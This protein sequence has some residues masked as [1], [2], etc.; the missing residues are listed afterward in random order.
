MEIASRQKKSQ[1]GS[2][3]GGSASGSGSG[4]GFFHGGYCHMAELQECD[5]HHNS[6]QQMLDMSSTMTFGELLLGDLQLAPFIDSNNNDETT[7]SCQFSFGESLLGELEFIPSTTF[8][9]DQLPT[10][11]HDPKYEAMAA[12]VIDTRSTDFLGDTGA[13]H[14]H[15]R[16]Y[17]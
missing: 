1:E 7:P 8:S 4:E 17:L 13:S 3:G 12:S 5:S 6:V 14:Q 9:T 2:G 16:E 10:Q 11:V 15:R